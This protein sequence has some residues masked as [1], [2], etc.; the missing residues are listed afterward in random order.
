MRCSDKEGGSIA[1]LLLMQFNVGRPNWDSWLIVVMF[2]GVMGL[3]LG[4]EEEP[5][6]TREWAL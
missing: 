2:S 5:L 3:D 1:S 6:T 4:S